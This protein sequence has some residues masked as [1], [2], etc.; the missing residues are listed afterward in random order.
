MMP[1]YLLYL[2]MLQIQEFI[3]ILMT[4]SSAVS[5]LSSGNGFIFSTPFVLLLA[6]VLHVYYISISAKPDTL[7]S[8]YFI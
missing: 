2:L 8:Y 4:L 3:A 6:S 7:Y 1:L 5:S